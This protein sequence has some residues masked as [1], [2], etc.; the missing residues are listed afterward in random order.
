MYYLA[1]VGQ[2][3]DS[4]GNFRQPSLVVTG[5]YINR[6]IIPLPFDY[7]ADYG[8]RKEKIFKSKI[9]DIHSFIK[10]ISKDAF[11]EGYL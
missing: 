7:L 1:V 5:P 2:S 10:S 9:E 4:N 6:G 8:N 11:V 3:R